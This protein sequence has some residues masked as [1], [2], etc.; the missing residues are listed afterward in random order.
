MNPRLAELQPY[1]F[2]KLAKLKSGIVPP[3]DKS[4]IALSIGEPKHPTPQFIKDA[5]CAGIDG[6]SNYP[7]T[8]GSIEL[9]SAISSWL[10]RRF[11]L[12]AD[13]ID[14]EKNV[15][16]VN[17]TREALFAIAQAVV[18][19][20]VSAFVMMPNPFYQIYEG[21]ALLSG[22]KPYFINCTIDGG[23]VPDFSSVPGRHWDRCQLL[24][25]CSPGNPTGAVLSADTLKE[26]IELSDRYNFVIASDECY[27]EI[28]FDEA[29][30]PLGLL[31]VASSMGS[32]DYRNCLVFHSLSKRSN[33]PGMRSGFVAGDAEILKTFL[34]YRTYQGCAMS[35]PIQAA[36]TVAWSDE[37]HV[38]QNRELYT[39][40]FDAVLEIISP[41]I[42]VRRPDAAFYLWPETPMLDED[43]ARELF[44]QQNVT[45]LPGSYLS[46]KYEGINPGQNRVRMALVASLD[47]CVEAARRIV[48]FIKT[49]R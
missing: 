49:E 22:A 23:T 26:L 17:G 44:R 27:S 20:S 4:A 35:P 25:I 13:S 32:S 40:K 41:I 45:V 39:K 36:S 14:P 9:R 24:Y 28:Y 3:E 8:I 29:A 33:V 19:P 21:A 15:L 1:P 46:R 16:P 34:H 11:K 30:P 38:K 31:Q 12:E 10:T 37:E 47:E 6:L 18:D 42:N 48:E 5:L 2:E 43:F 7:M